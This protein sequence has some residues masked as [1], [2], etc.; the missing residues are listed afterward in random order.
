MTNR[1]LITGAGGLVGSALADHLR[2]EG[3]EVISLTSRSQCDLTNSHEVEAIFKF[4][5]P[6]QVHHLAA[7]VFG[8]GGNLSFPGEI[9]YRNV[10]MNTHVVEACRKFNVKKIVAMGSAAMY[11]DGL[12]QPMREDHVMLGEPHGS[13]FAYAYSKRAMLAQL[14]AYKQQYGLEFAFIVATNMYGAKDRFDTSYGHVVPSLL[15]KFLDAEKS[16][17]TVEV[18]GDGTPTRDFLYSADAALGLQLIMQNGSGVFNLA[19]GATHTI[20]ELVLEVA[21]NFP[22]VLFTWNTSKPLG[23]LQRSYDISRIN[24]LGF[25][26]TYSLSDGIK[27][28][29]SWMRK[30]DI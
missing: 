10:M 30:N 23:Q 17:D 4:T 22:N 12:Q 29:I 11:S 3:H 14:K 8:V 18:W 16:G 25:A 24:D 19:S 9:Y 15:K 6:T 26:P 2:T 5:Q 13:E 1:T 21:K 28:T 7:S 27:S 20:K